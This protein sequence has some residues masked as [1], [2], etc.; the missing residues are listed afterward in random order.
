MTITIPYKIDLRNYQV[1]MWEFLKEFKRG[2]FL[3]HRRAGKDVVAWSVMIREAIINVGAYYY[4]FPTYEQARKVIWEG[5][6]NTEGVSFLDMIPP[7]LIVSKNTQQLSFTLWNG[8]IIR[9][10][11]S[12]RFNALRGTN[13]IGI[14]FSEFAFQNPIVWDI[15][16]PI[17]RAN[18]G[19]A[20]FITT[21]NG[22]NHAYDLWNQA[23]KN[24]NWFTQKLT[25]EDT[26]LVSEADIEEERRSGM[27]EAL[28]RQEYFLDWNAMTDQVVYGRE[29]TLA[30]DRIATVLYDPLLP[31]QTFFDLGRSDAT[32]IIF[33]QVKGDQ[34]RIIDSYENVG[35]GV[36]H[37]AQILREKGYS[38]TPLGLPHDAAAKRMES[39][40]S[41]QQQ[42]EDAGFHTKIV[43]NIGIANGIA[44]VRR[45]FYSFW[46]DSKKTI[47]LIRALKSYHYT[48]DAN[49]K[50]YSS[51]PYHNFASHFADALRMLAVGIEM[52][53]AR[54][55]NEDRHVSFYDRKI[56]RT[57][58]DSL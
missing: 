34:I 38:Y 52:K 8:S 12:D 6:L 19:W 37:Y 32:T 49:R 25:I 11:G 22:E 53:N 2:F 1:D 13:P 35:E 10:I 58:A 51:E 15:V 24:P 31:V 9:L 28:I 23:Q 16:R 50:V 3:F 42:F 21:P 47:P 46:F 4:V 5:I 20:I 18:K 41:I 30:K 7:E 26:K 48:F 40:L 27:S 14:V 39:E 36:S 45:L 29:L 44:A 57:F 56:Q 55:E 33:A 17:L 54:L 43:P